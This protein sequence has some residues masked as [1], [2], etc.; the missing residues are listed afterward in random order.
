MKLL[1][2][3]KNDIELYA[4]AISQLIGIDVEIMGKNFKR[5]VGTGLLKDKVGQNMYQDSHVYRSV[6]YSGELCIIINPREEEICK[7]CPS[8]EICKETLEISTPI[9]FNEDIVGVIGLICFDQKQKENFLL[10][11]DLYINFI[12][13]ISLSITSRLHQENEK[14]IAKNNNELLLNIIDRIPDSIIITN[15]DKKIEMINK[16]GLTLL[17]NINSNSKIKINNETKMSDKKEFSLEYNNTTHDVI[18]DIIEINNSTDNSKTLYIFQESDKFRTYLQQINT[19]L[20]KNFIFSSPE[21][22]LIYSKIYKVAKTTSTVFITGESG[23]G[24]EVVA[25]LIHSNSD[26]KDKPFIAVNCGAI[27]DSLIESEFFGYVKGAFTGANPNGKI[28]FFE[29]ANEG[30]IFLDEIGDMPLSLQ[31]KLL[32]VLQEKVICPIGSNNSKKIDIR[33]IAATNREP[34]ELVKENKFREDLY[35]RLN[36]FPIDIPPLR[37]RKKDIEDLAKYFI[38]KYSKLFNRSNIKI[39]D[40]VMEFFQSYS[41]P[42]NIRELKNVTEY[43]VNVIEEKDNEILLK[44]LPNKLFKSSNIIEDKT[45]AEIEKE[46]IQNLLIKYGSSSKD[47]EKI[48]EILDIGIATLYRKIKLYNL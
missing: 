22:S 5:L 38:R 46:T 39:S 35:Y 21:M 4:D 36:V 18:G 44:H 23:T 43:I 13:Q 28:G 11:K 30:T 20:S 41:W 12:K 27:P 26:R 1:E 17:K 37:N 7:T 15:E 6:L 45:L 14:I 48:S 25:R 31:V 2:N 10:K 40:E 29:Q 42:G 16:S 24:K 32:R 19:N 33:V 3:I 8:R 34:E 9:F 47:K